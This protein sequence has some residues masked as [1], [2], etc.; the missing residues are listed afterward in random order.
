MAIDRVRPLKIESSTTGGTQLNLRPTDLDPTQDFVDCKGI[1]FNNT[2]NT[3]IAENS[4]AIQL[5]TSNTLQASLSSGGALSLTN[6]LG[7]SSGGTNNSSAYTSGSI[8]FSNGTSLTQDNSTLFW[9]NTNKRLGIGTATPS[10]R[11]QIVETNTGTSGSLF[12]ASINQNIN[13]SSASTA[14]TAGLD[15]IAVT[16]TGS[17]D[18]GST[19]FGSRYLIHRNSTDSGAITTMRGIQLQAINAAALSTGQGSVT[20]L[21]GA[22]IQGFDNSNTTT[23]TTTL[24]GASIAT[25]I[26]SATVSSRVFTTVEGVYIQCGMGAGSTSTTVTNLNLIN[27]DC[28]ITGALNRTG[29]I[30]NPIGVN[31]SGW[32]TA[33]VFG[34]GL[35]FTNAPEYIRM[36]TN[37][38]SGAMSLRSQG[39]GVHMRHVGNVMIGT[40]AAPNANLEIRSAAGT[41]TI[42]PEFLITAGAHTALTASTEH[43]DFHYNGARSVQWATGSLT[44][45][46]F[47]VFAAPTI[48][49]VGASTLTDTATVAVSGAPVKSTNAT[50]TN[51]HAILV[52]AGAV[53][54]ATN[55]YGLTVNAQTGATNNYAAQFQGRVGISTS[56]PTAYL[57][58]GAG[59]ASANTAPLKFTSGTNLTA[60]EAGAVEYDGKKLTVS[61]LGTVTRQ[62]IST[63]LNRD[64]TL[65]TVSSSAAEITTYTFT[66]PG[67]TLGSDRKL[68]FHAMGHVLNNKGTSGTIQYRIYYGATVIYNATHTV[69]NNADERAVDIK[70][71]LMAANSTTAQE[72]NGI[73]L[74]GKENTVAG[75]AAQVSDTFMAHHHTV[76]EDSTANKVFKLTVTL[77][78]ASASFTSTTH[79]CCLEYL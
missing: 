19:V 2:E 45:Q 41:G 64:V 38:I 29:T 30:T 43:I 77:N 59:T 75:V 17:T 9:D 53:S 71:W 76:A 24:R 31:F 37:S 54:T 5:Y 46:R 18:K 36:Q 28:A 22:F 10:Y 32:T 49:F 33:G 1:A 13:P 52:Q 62:E 48:T 40:D 63:V 66:V 16:S 39:S 23:A 42:N 55:S 74:V 44:T 65:Q 8:I 6:A 35:T 73:S 56:A 67:G 78:A 60:A 50:I 58:I 34:S 14:T 4:G 12:C 25:G 57:H 72:A 69:A 27:V 68:A 3:R 61:S 11:T 21:E 70:C 7:I 47:A 20:T 79:T 15:V 26:S 51:T